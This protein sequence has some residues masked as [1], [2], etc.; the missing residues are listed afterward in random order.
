MGHFIQYLLVFSA[1]EWSVL[2]EFSP[3][4]LH[5]GCTMLYLSFHYGVHRVLEALEM[6]HCACVNPTQGRTLVKCVMYTYRHR[7][8]VNIPY[9]FHLSGYVQFI[10]AIFKYGM[11]ITR[12]VYR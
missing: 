5:A 4:S 10:L 9:L 7:M 1:Y 3:C 6:N 12:Q 11:L 8:I 2:Y